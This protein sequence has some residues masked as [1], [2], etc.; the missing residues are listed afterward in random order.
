MHKTKVLEVTSELKKYE[1][2]NMKK[3]IEDM[4]IFLEDEAPVEMLQEATNMTLENATE[5]M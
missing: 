5:I 1:K 4:D 2:E 3:E